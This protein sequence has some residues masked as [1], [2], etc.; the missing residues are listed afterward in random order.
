METQTVHQMAHNHHNLSLQLLQLQNP[1]KTHSTKITDVPAEVFAPIMAWVP[2]KQVWKLRELSKVFRALI[3]TEAFARLNIGNFVPAPNLSVSTSTNPAEW[4]RLYLKSPLSYQPRIKLQSELSEI[5]TEIKSIKSS[6]RSSDSY[7]DTLQLSLTSMEAHMVHQMSQDHCILSLQLVQRQTPHKRH[8]TKITDVSAEVVGQMLAR[9]PPKE[10]WR[11]RELSRAFL[12]L[13]ETDA[14]AHL[15]VGHFVL[16]PDLAVTEF[17]GPSKFECIYLKSPP[18]YQRAFGQI[19][20]K[21]LTRMRWFAQTYLLGE[22]PTPIAILD[23]K[24]LKVLAI[25]SCGVVGPIPV[26]MGSALSGLHIL[27]FRDNDLTGSIPPSIGLLKC[28][29]KLYL[30]S[31]QLSGEIPPELGALASLEKLDLSENQDLSGPLP[32]QLGLLKNL[33]HLFLSGT[34]VSGSI[35]FEWGDLCNL[36]VLNLA[37]NRGLSGTIPPS[38]G[39]LSLLQCLSLESCSFSGSIPPELGRLANLEEIFLCDN[40]LS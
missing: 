11:L 16:K 4:D 33:K 10:V 12:A 5:H 3:E 27:T 36:Q 8:S 30:S 34:N 29:K 9:I 22:I 7:I 31:N 25:E 32:P 35:P 37:V 17:Y 14:F 21:H 28:L 18:S 40:K 1:H 15:N 20:W 24:N 6:L 23:C 39:N 19:R 26:E 38:L 2:P 13:I